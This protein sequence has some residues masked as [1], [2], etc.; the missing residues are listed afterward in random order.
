M[1][2]VDGRH[3]TCTTI[4]VMQSRYCTGVAIWKPGFVQ[5][6]GSSL[7]NEPMREFQ[8]QGVSFITEFY[9]QLLLYDYW[10]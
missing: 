10:V 1:H 7:W 4:I 5:K 6:T 8:T 9:V 2:V 3:C